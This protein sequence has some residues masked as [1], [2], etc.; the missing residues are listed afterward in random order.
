MPYVAND[1]VK[2][3]IEECQDAL[4]AASVAIAKLTSDGPL[5]R[6]DFEELLGELKDQSV[7][8]AEIEDTYLPDVTEEEEAKAVSETEIE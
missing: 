8:A 7:R 1:I 5:E 3:A 4:E 6:E 2:Q